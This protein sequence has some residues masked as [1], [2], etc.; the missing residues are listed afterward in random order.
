MSHLVKLSA[1]TY[2]LAFI[3]LLHIRSFLQFLSFGTSWGVG[4]STASSVLH[5]SQ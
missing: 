2:M 4:Q 1:K 3:L 5:Y